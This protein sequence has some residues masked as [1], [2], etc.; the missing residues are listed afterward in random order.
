M[1]AKGKAIFLA[2]ILAGTMTLTGGYDMVYASSDL[3]ENVSDMHIL[4]QGYEWG[5]GVP[6]IILQLKEEVSSVSA[7]AGSVTTAGQ[8]RTVTDIYTCD[9]NG[10]KTEGASD[11]IAIEMAT[12]SQNAGSPLVYDGAVLHYKWADT[13]P[14]KVEC[15]QLVVDG[16]NYTYSASVD[17]IDK[18]ICPDTE[19]FS[20]RDAFT[21]TYLNSFT[22]EEEEMTLHTIA[23]EPESLAGGEKNPLIIW[24]HG[25]WEGGENPDIT[26]LGNEACALA[27][28]EIQNYFTA[29][30]ETGAY[31]LSIQCETFWM[32]EG[33]GTNGLGSGISKYTEILMDTIARYVE[34]NTDVDPNRIYLGG[35][36]NGGYMTVNM[37]VNYP[38]YFA[39]AFPCCE[40]YSFY[41]FGRNAN[42][43]YKIDASA[44]YS[45]QAVELTGNRWMTDEK[46]EAIK[47]VPM[48]FTLAIND[49]TVFPKAFGL[50]TYQALVQAGADNCWLSVF[51]NV[52]GTDDPAASYAGHSVWVY[53]FNNQITGVQDRD[54]IVA[55]ADD[56]FGVVPTNA[57]GGTLSADGHS[58]LYEWLNAQ[59]K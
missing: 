6:K 17:C 50:P 20:V 56:N 35:A 29:G 37:L 14:V 23:Y 42:G 5:P 4:V 48:W 21:G 34:S 2:G 18:Q 51:E 25:Q 53:L 31:V 32:D 49:G 12:S 54:K 8:A 11:Y 57:G 30:N 19:R 58:N 22:G 39:A 46:I 40:A 43:S 44:G 27:R 38:D 7:N 24:L 13:Y 9:A 45:L 16:E 47:N 55:A 15:P 36:S 41:E 52:V 3:Y 59:S 10:E 26:L 28:D 33:D 1:K